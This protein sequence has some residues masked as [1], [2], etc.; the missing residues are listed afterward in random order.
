[1]TGRILRAGSGAFAFLALLLAASA[2]S[3]QLS[4]ES[5]NGRT[6]VSFD[7]E[8]SGGHNYGFEL[9]PG[10]AFLLE[11]IPYG[12]MIRVYDSDGLDLSQTTPPFHG[13]NARE[14][15]GWHFRNAANT[16]ANI[17][18]VNAPQELRL[19]EFSPALTGTG[20]YRPPDGALEIEPNPDDGRA[21]LRILDYGLA[22][23]EPGQQA[24]MVY[25]HFTACLTWPSSY[26]P[27]EIPIVHIGFEPEDIERI[28]ACGLPPELDPLDYL[29]P[30][31][32]DGDFDGDGALDFATP[33][34]R[35]SDGK[36]GLAICRAGTW[37][38]VIGLEGDLGQLQ[39]PYFDR[40]DWWAV[41]TGPIQQGVSEGPPPPALGDTLTIGINDSSS[42][43][44]YW[45][46]TRFQAYWQGD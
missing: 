20:G 16:G 17:G 39:P 36:R 34:A 33:I 15:E 13:P 40:M 1:M 38:D 46:G 24:R 31:T 42:V 23:L 9:A 21:W 12:Y 28:R 18:D 4:C 44:L 3:A 25:L 35:A 14:I 27:P 26:D 2:A 43:K 7:G 11:P 37:L 22:D 32:L 45:D 19:F 10:W 5:G 41:E 8:V 6:A 30:P 29:Q